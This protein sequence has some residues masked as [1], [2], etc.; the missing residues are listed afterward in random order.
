MAT[1]SLSPPPPCPD[2]LIGS[3]LPSPPPPSLEPQKDLSEQARRIRQLER[4]VA[5]LSG[6]AAGAGVDVSSILRLAAAA[7]SQPDMLLL[8]AEAAD[9]V[10]ETAARAAGG[11]GQARTGGSA[12]GA[13]HTEEV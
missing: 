4:E 7:A 5:A 1:R 13:G 11:G 6:A 3:Q 8:Q 10:S 9:A 2:G 12:R